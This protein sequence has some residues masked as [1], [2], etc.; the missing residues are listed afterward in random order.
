MPKRGK[1]NVVF[2]VQKIR[3]IGD[4]IGEIRQIKCKKMFGNLKNFAHNFS[5]S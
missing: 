2:P 5:K 3:G 1:Y 4:V